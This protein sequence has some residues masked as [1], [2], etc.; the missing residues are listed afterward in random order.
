MGISWLLNTLAKSMA[1]LFVKEIT[2]LHGMLHSIVSDKDS[3]FTGQF[4]IE[5]FWI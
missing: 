3:I 5:Y 4:W 2:C 1:E